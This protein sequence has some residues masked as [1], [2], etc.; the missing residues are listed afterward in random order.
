MVWW[1]T[2]DSP[3]SAIKGWK[4]TYR[5]KVLHLSI[6][7]VMCMSCIRQTA[8]FFFVIGNT[9]T[10][11]HVLCRKEFDLNKHGRAFFRTF[12]CLVL[13]GAKMCSE[14]KLS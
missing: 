14:E 9:I 3:E 7:A 13:S 4:F 12:Y 6:V 10:S 8:I 11:F 5:S 1:I 2:C